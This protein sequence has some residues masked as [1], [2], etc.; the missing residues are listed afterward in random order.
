MTCVLACG[1]ARMGEVCLAPHRVPL[2]VEVDG[3]DHGRLRAR[4]DE[5][6]D[7]WLQRHGYTVLRLSDALVLNNIG[8]A[9]GLIAEQV[10]A[11]RR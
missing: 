8:V 3:G 4:S 10:A 1:C 2:V 11:L 9:V 5:R 7:R 6:R